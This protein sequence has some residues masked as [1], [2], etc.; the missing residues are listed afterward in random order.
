MEFLFSLFI[1]PQLP[2]G[3]DIQDMLGSNF[4][5][6]DDV[7]TISYV[8]PF[9]CTLFERYKSDMKGQ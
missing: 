4:H 5:T 3:T 6:L 2:V 9:F 1:F 8:N 7:K